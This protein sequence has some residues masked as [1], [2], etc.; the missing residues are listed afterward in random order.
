MADHPDCPTEVLDRVMQS[1]TVRLLAYLLARES[2]S[3]VTNATLRNLRTDISHLVVDVVH[4]IGELPLQ[5]RE[6]IL[7]DGEH[8]AP[9][10]PAPAAGGPAPARAPLTGPGSSRR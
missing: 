5:R 9:D 7:P 3:D 4:A 8:A 10:V 1:P 2:G 6:I